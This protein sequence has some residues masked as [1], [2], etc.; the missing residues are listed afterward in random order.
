M[1]N[2]QLRSAAFST[3]IIVIS[4]AIILGSGGTGTPAVAMVAGSSGISAV[5]E[6]A[7]SV[8]GALEASKI[9]SV[10][11]RD[12]LHVGERA[13]VEVFDKLGR[14]LGEANPITGEIIEGT[15]DVAKRLKLK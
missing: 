11:D 1:T 5:A 6:V 9:A 7:S 10:S 3:C 8:A 2:E 12:T 13:H 4:A 15:I 14:H